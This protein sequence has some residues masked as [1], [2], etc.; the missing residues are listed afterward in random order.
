M[1]LYDWHFAPNPRRVRMFLAEKGLD[2]PIEEVGVPGKLCLKPEFVARFDPYATA[3]TLE[4][5]DGTC[6]G[7]AMAICRY[8][9]DLHPEPRLMGKDALSK[10]TIEMWERRAYEGAMLAIGE[11]LR[12][13][14]P[15]FVDRGL[16]GTSETIEQIPALVERGRGRLSRFRRSADKQLAKNAFLAGPSFSVADVTAYCAIDFLGRVVEMPIPEELGNL[17]RWLGEIAA[18][19]SA[20]ATA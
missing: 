3:P 15:G 1:K 4:L 9:E 14:N 5:D 20:K 8:L 17:R 6:I 13:T 7:E 2:V 12:N 11:L 16:P 18:R 19:P 10:A